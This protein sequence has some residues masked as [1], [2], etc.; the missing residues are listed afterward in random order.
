MSKHNMFNRKIK[1]SGNLIF[2]TAFHIGSGKEGELATNMG[3]LR[4][5][6]G[7]PILPGSTLKG[8]FRAFAERLS[9]HLGF[10]ACLL[11]SSLSGKNCVSDENFRK[12]KLN[13]FQE[14]KTEDVKINWL[15]EKTCDICRLFGSPLQASRIFFSD[16][17][18]I[19]WDQRIQIRDGVCIDRDTETARPGAKYDFEVASAGTVFK[20]NIELENPDDKD[21][22][23]VAAVL[24]EWENGFRLGGFTSRG[25]GRARFVDKKVEYVDYT[26]F[27]QLKAYLLTK[28]MTEAGSLLDDNLRSALQVKEG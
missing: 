24:S 22:A 11:D 27:D 26:N 9:D 1:I 7:S 3:I 12:T 5:A 19:K 10:E 21:L 18:L 15:N 8:N 20:I 23:I 6:D 16:G 13:E 2:D 28:Q 17:T 14:L 4:E 25:L